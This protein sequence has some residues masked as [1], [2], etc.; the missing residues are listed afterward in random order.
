MMMYI[1]RQVLDQPRHVFGVRSPPV[2]ETLTHSDHIND[3]IVAENIRWQHITPPRGWLSIVVS[4]AS[5]SDILREL[6]L[7][8]LLRQEIFCLKSFYTQLLTTLIG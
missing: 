7:R 6:S 8:P 5:H 1:V 4:V 3:K 2:L